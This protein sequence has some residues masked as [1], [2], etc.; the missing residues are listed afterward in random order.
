LPIAVSL[1]D[2]LF[3]PADGYTKLDLVEYYNVNFL[4]LKPYVKE[5]MQSLDI[6]NDSIWLRVRK[7]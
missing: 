7:W 5:R 3:W 2:K 6:F 1:P 4:R